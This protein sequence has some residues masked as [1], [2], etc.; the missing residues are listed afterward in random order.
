MTNLSHDDV[1]HYSGLTFG[2]RTDSFPAHV[3]FIHI[4]KAGGGTVG[5]FL[6]T[7]F[8]KAHE[9]HV[10]PVPRI[11]LSQ[12]RRF[13]VSTRDPVDRFLS[14]YR[15]GVDFQ[16]H[17]GQEIARVDT[18]RCSD[19]NEFAQLFVEMRTRPLQRL[20]GTHSACAELVLGLADSV[21]TRRAMGHFSHVVMDACFYLG[22]CIQQLTRSNGLFVVTMEDIEID[23]LALLQWMQLKQRAEVQVK[24]IH[25]LNYMASDELN[26]ASRAALERVLVDDYNILN[27][28]LSASVNKFEAAYCNTGPHH[29]A[30]AS[31][32]CVWRR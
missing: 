22:G 31:S 2:S 5:Q 9:V 18:I 1:P 11:A 3:L 12:H 20:N 23:L 19:V 25:K 6:S 4:G 16:R 17:I 29:E 28:L 30:A 10:H 21:P 27:H 32:T 13:V 15:W 7:Q 14:A 24:H 26:A 8:A